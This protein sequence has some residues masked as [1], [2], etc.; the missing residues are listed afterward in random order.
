MST[1]PLTLRAARPIVWM[2]AV[3][4]RRKPSLSASR[5]AT[6][7]TS[8]RSRPSR[9]RLTP[10]STSNSPRRRSRIDLDALEGVDLGVQVARPHARLEQ[11]VG[12][13][14]GHLLGQR[15]A[16]APARRPPR[17]AGSRPAGRRSGGASAAPR[18]RG[19]SRPVGRMI[20]S[21]TCAD[22]RSS[23]GARRG[24]DEDGLRHAVDELVEA[25][26][27]VV[28]RRR[29]AEAVARPATRLRERSPSYMR[30]DLRHGLVRLVDEDQVVAR[31]VV[32]QR[33]RRRARRAPV[34]DARVVLDA[35]AVA[36]ARASSPCRTRCAGAAGAPRAACW[37]TRSSAT[38]VLELARGSPATARSMV[39]GDVT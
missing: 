17:A 37:P 27:P 33:E 29:Q 15:R 19:R 25:Q 31:E 11:V 2:R 20:C 24:R 13:V 1:R 4:P 16:R 14:L 38:R 9:S 5:I 22:W 28:E 10:T 12:Q 34:E 32:E 36:R 23:N 30:A 26:R 7:E 3:C 8:G 18:P 39:G 35:V 21:T 6:S